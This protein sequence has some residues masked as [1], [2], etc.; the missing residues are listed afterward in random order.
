MHEPAPD[1]QLRVLLSEEQSKH[2]SLNFL[3]HYKVHSNFFD[4]QKFEKNIQFFI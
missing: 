2:L 3:S 4:H 1:N